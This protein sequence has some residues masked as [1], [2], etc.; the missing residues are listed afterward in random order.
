M[1]PIEFKTRLFW[2]ITFALAAICLCLSPLASAQQLAKRLILKDGSYQLTTKWE[3]KGDRIRYYSAERGEWEEIPDS[4]IDWSATDKY[5]KD[6]AAGVPPPEAVALDKELEAERKAEEL[7]SPQVAPGLR[8]PDESGV[9]LLDNFQSQPQ[10]NELQQNGGEL[11]K[12]M[13]GNILRAAINPIA[14]AKQTIELKGEHAKVQS[15]VTIPALYV[16]TT[17]EKDTGDASRQPQQPQQPEQP[18]QLPVDRFKIVRMQA[19]QD[20]RIVG[21]IKIAVYGKVSQEQKLVPTTS[22]PIS[23]GWVKVTPTSAL[24]PGEYA[25]VEMLGKEGMNL[26][27]WDFGVNPTAP[28]NPMASKPDPRAIPQPKDKPVELEKRDQH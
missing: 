15:H 17:Q 22:Q 2:V 11:N 24:T 23:G 21:D 20:K 26:F 4:L 13:K 3:K 28:A 9:F 6:R 25:L 5:E 12:N 27:V 1:L 18:I 14:S 7:R 10:L 19:K 8:L 16:N